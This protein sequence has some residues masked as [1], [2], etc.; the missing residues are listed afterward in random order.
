MSKQQLEKTQMTRVSFKSAT[1]MSEQLALTLTTDFRL[2]ERMWKSRGVP[3]FIIAPRK[4]GRTSF[5][6]D[7][8]RYQYDLDEVLWINAASVGF[9]E[10][11]DRQTMLEH[12]MQQIMSGLSRYTLI[13]VDDLPFLNER[14]ALHFSNW[15]NQLIEAAVSIIIITTPREDSMKNCQPERL[16]I[17][18][19]QFILM[20]KWSKKR[21]V[22]CLESFF[23]ASIHKDIKIL[24]ALML[25]M[26]HGTV[27]N[28]IDLGY[29]IPFSIH[30][31]VKQHCPLLEIDE[32]T[33]YFNTG[34]MPVKELFPQLSVLLNQ[35]PGNEA[36][37]K[38]SDL[39]RC[40]ERLTQ[41]S[42]YL[43]E[44]SEREQS[45]MLLELAG[46]LLT[47]DDAGFMISER[48]GD[49][50]GAVLD[51]EKNTEAESQ[52]KTIKG[53]TIVINEHLSKAD[54]PSVMNSGFDESEPEQ[55]II[56][57]FGDFKVIKGGRLI[58]G[59]HLQRSKVRALLIHLTL[60]MGRGLARDTLLDRIWP[61]KDYFH[62]KDNFYSTWSMLGSLLSEGKRSCPYLSNKQGI[63]RLEQKYVTTDIN[64]F[65]R[66]SRTVLFRQGS[67]ED[68]ID[69]IY[70]LEQLY[71]GDIMSGT[72]VDSYVQAAQSRYRSILVDIM[73][74][75][76]RIF[77]HEGNDTNA[78]WF[79]RKAYDTDPTREDVY[80]TLMSVQDK[81]GQRTSALK[82]Y[83]DCK[84]FLSEEL[85]ILPSQ[86]TIALYQELV[87]DRR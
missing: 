21:K 43:F 47:C 13:V 80:R 27:D 72:K 59:K 36:D 19:E 35:A 32:T 7:Y 74:E 75:A 81:A 49:E 77:S 51:H 86:Q 11:L 3:I 31:L 55:L 16:L 61:G 63:C 10:A 22:E 26:G 4:T 68:R 29:Q 70:R 83:F 30:S 6:L 38:M 52:G 82:T 9:V 65:E 28:L 17:M 40:F 73:I 34:G 84:R 53:E 15:I 12:L 33:G 44:R 18:G 8:A 45:Q 56:R 64:E 78:V 42:V 85:G 57:L 71:R 24:T 14:Q 23:A 46:S 58:E 1:E 76:S 67:V 79:A 5:V 25:L 41:M 87:M 60:N 54:K 50:S 20:Q 66:L 2:F 39:E 37:S 69:A 62:A 48:H